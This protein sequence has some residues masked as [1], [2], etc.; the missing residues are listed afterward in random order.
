M[1]S[2]PANPTDEKRSSTVLVR[3]VTGQTEEHRVD[4]NEGIADFKLRIGRKIGIVDAAQIKLCFGNVDLSSGT[5]ASNGVYDGAALHLTVSMKSG[6]V[7]DSPLL[8]FA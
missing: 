7:I 8:S 3:N 5:L 4:L 2:D 6:P 1:D